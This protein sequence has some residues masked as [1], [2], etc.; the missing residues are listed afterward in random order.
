MNDFVSR[1]LW[2]RLLVSSESDVRHGFFVPCSR[3]DLYRGF[4]DVGG[5]ADDSRAE[6]ACPFCSEDFEIMGLCRHIDD[7]HRGEAK[8][9]VFPLHGHT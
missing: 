5:G 7:E 9:G 4:E 8:N 3:A 6:F 2:N 1:P